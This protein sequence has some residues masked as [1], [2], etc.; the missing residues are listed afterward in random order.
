[1]T[2]G[3]DASAGDVP[4]RQLHERQLRQQ[5][6][7]HGKARDRQRHRDHGGTDAGNYT[8]NTTADDDR[9]HHRARAGRHGDRREQGVRR[10]D[11]GDVDARGRP[12]RRRC[13]HGAS[14]TSA[15]FADKNV[16]T[17]KAVTVSGIAISGA[18]RR[19][20]CSVNTT[21]TTTANITPR[22]LTVTATG[23]NKVYDGTTDG[24]GHAQRRPGRRRCLHGELHQRPPL[25]T[26]TSAAARRV[27]CH[28]HHA[29]RR[30]RGNYS[31]ANTTASTT[32][33]ITRASADGDRD[34][35]QQGLRRDDR[36]DRDAGRRPRQ[37]GRA[38][39]R[40]TPS[41]TFADKHV[42]TG[43]TVSVSGIALTGGADAG[44]LHARQHHGHGDRG[45][46]RADADRDGHRR[47]QGL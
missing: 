15:S 47:Q 1:M 7:G 10:H 45:H 44:Q 6:R 22:A 11:D 25:P 46:H 30:G 16:G 33:N 4:H 18:R 32:A 42:G 20:L 29:L 5:E 3:D 24:D 41:A 19:Q 40:P 17:G 43:K 37:R 39:G 23:V 26:S 31:L 28:R 12:R 14:Y 34:R 13:L 36:R 21:A 35:C 38:H 27:T 2:L 8:L 9:R